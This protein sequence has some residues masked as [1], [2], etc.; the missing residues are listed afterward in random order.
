MKM[1]FNPDT[2]KKVIEACFSQKREKNNY[3]S[4]TLNSDNVQ[5]ANKQ[6]YLQTGQ[7][8]WGKIKKSSKTGEGHKNLI[9]NFACF[10]IAI[11]KV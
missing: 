10:L 5:S 4:L 2:I 1:L 7:N 8:I 11:V 9:S 3:T 6:R